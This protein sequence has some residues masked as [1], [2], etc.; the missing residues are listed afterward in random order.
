[1]S[2]RNMGLAFRA[3]SIFTAVVISLA[4]SATIASAQTISWRLTTFSP[5]GNADFRECV[6]R[7]VKNVA[8]TTG[9]EVK[10]Q[11]FGAGVIA[12]AFETPQAVQKGLADV[13]IYFPG[14]MVNDDPTNALLAG[15]PGG[16]PAEPTMAWLAYGGGEKLWQQ[17]RREKMGLQSVVAC[18]GPS[19]VFAHS[20]KALRKVEDF[21]G[22]KI[23]TTGAWAVILK[24]Y[25]GASPVVL[26]AGEIFT[27]LER[28]VIDATEYV[29]PSIN[30]ATGLHNV[31]KYVIL[32]GIHQPTY[33]YEF[34]IKADAW[35]KLRGDLKEKIAA[36]AKLTM[37]EGLLK[38]S[39]DD[40]A[41]IQKMK[42]TGKNE[43]V[44]LDPS[45]MST[46]SK[47]GREWSAKVGAEQKA[48]GNAWME[49]IMGSYYEFQDK[50]NGASDIRI[51]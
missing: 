45:F 26:P 21:K 33:V 28:H 19:E 1:M 46:V 12:P 31:A 24:D 5:E 16:M 34:M 11:A 18:I 50:W 35:D 14:Y 36:A 2:P 6:E 44:V 7:F 48:K 42:A 27:A 47:Y 49:K 15:L 8:L 23:R 13:A 39:V 40:I 9:G 29:T 3:M 17:F 43:F 37:M 30:L 10:I 51:K 38:L 20:H 4:A 32:P 41:A 22:L 25:L